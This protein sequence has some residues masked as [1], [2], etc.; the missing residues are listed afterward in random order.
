MQ[1]KPFGDLFYGVSSDILPHP[2]R[3]GLREPGAELVEVSDEP[4]VLAPVRLVDQ[5]TQGRA[6]LQIPRQVSND[7]QPQPERRTSA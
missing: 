5:R 7:D 1:A 4:D 2:S 6:A 3:Y